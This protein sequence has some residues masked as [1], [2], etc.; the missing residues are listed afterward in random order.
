MVQAYNIDMK[1]FLL[2]FNPAA[3]RFP[4]KPFIQSIVR[5]LSANHWRVHV[6]ETLNGRH[7]TQLA[8]Q[9]GLE[10]YYAAFAIGGDGTVGQVANGLL[11]SDT[12]LGVLPAGTAN[13]WAR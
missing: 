2:I 3:G 1:D 12:A 7:S 6:A 4:V 13:V 11:G 8:R 10:N 9:A 5:T